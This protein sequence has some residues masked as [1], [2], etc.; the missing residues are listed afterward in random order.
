MRLF[1]AACTAIAL[2]SSA[3]GAD[4]RSANPTN[5][6]IP[7]AFAFAKN[8]PGQVTKISDGFYTFAHVG[9]R[10]VFFVTGKGVI[11]TDPLNE[12]AARMLRE[13]IR[14]ITDQPVKYVIYS[15][16]HWDHAA[17]G[18]IFKDE[19]AKF[20]AQERCVDYFR[21]FPNPD[22]IEP[23][24]TYKKDYTLRLGDRRLKLMYL[25]PNHSDCMTFI[26]VEGTP[27]LVMVDMA[28]PGSLPRG[29]MMDYAL[30]HWVRT[31][32]EVEAMAKDGVTTVVEGHG[33]PSAP[34]SAATER[35][36]YLEAL[37]AEVKAAMEKGVPSDK[38]A[39]SIDMAKF[40]H[41]QNWDRYFKAN[42]ARV[43]SYYSIGY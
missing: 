13:E 40:R 10:N 23:D 4:S 35:R 34:L 8:I 25:G 11:V 38:I 2:A 42:V 27:Y 33:P 7:S 1:I 28:N 36:E 21:N 32:K 31:L 9:G 37:M 6:K 19:G 22:V 26:R 14:K 24:I 15:H 41:M 3:Y 18:R 16:P 43:A 12:W 30:H 29:D 5:A 20:I 39:D 17:G